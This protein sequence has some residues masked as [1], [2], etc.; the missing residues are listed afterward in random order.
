MKRCLLAACV[1]A[2]LLAPA[3]HAA[4]W[5]GVV[6]GKSAAKHAILTTHAGGTVRMVRV[7]SMF[8]RVGIGRQV[9]VRATALR[10][11]TFRASHV[12]VGAPA[13]TVEFEA[14]FLGRTTDGKLRVAV[15]KRGE[16]FVTVPAT[17]A[18]PPLAPGDVIELLVSVD[19][20][21]AFTLVRIEAQ[22]EQENE[23][24]EVEVKGTI[25][26]LDAF[27]ITVSPRT[28]NPVTCSIPT[29]SPVVGFRIGDLVEMKCVGPAQHLVLARLKAEDDDENEENENR[30]EG[31]RGG[32]GGE[33]REGGGGHGRH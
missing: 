29:T 11:G 14:I 1:A 2:L 23:E 7:G 8:S 3:S 24:N 25:T 20:A 33:G 32:H 18:L 21:G 15:A 6:I 5:K 13:S 27:S 4:A 19:Q 16:V 31:H 12:G 28:G 9:T 17:F 22:N 26:A 10:D 30:G